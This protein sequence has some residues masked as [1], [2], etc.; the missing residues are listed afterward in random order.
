MS[1]VILLGEQVSGRV[2]MCDLVHDH[3]AIDASHVTY[4]NESCPTY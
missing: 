2:C 4:I 1:S 3:T